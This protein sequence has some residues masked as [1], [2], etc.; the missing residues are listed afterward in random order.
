MNILVSWLPNLTTYWDKF[1]E[2]CLATF[3]MFFISGIFSFI[4]GLLF[5]VL[6]TV[7]K[8]G[9][10]AS[11]KIVYGIL[12][13]IINIF[14]AIPF[15]ILLIFLIPFTRAI[16]GTSIGVKGA[17]IPLV[18][19]CVPFFS[20]QVE[21]ALENV[22]PGKIEAARSMGSSTIGIIF[23]VYLHE[24]VPELI[25]VTTI[26]AI[27]LIGLTTMA[28]A[29]GAGGLGDFAI[30]Y[31][32]GLNHYDI[33][34]ACIIVLL[35]FTCIVQ[36]IGS[37]LAKKTTNREL[38]RFKTNDKKTNKVYTITSGVGFGLA[39]ILCI[40]VS[41]TISIGTQTNG[42]KE[43]KIGV[44][45]A[46]NDQW[47]AVQYV[48]DKQ[49]ANI[50]IDLVEFAAYDLPNQALDN[51]EIDLNSFQHN[52]YLEN[53][54]KNKLYNITAIGDTFLAPLTIYS[55]KYETLED[56]KTTA[57]LN[58]TNQVLNDALKI[59][60][61][62]DAT[63]QGRAIKLLE[64]AG[65]I[66]VNPDAKYTPETRDI[67]KY[68]YNIEVIAQAANTLPS[69]LDDYAAATIND[70]YANPAG[71]KREEDGIFIENKGDADNPYVNIIVSRENEKDNEVYK[72]IVEAFQTQIV[73]NFIYIEFDYS[74]IPAFD[75]TAFAELDENS[76]KEA[77]ELHYYIKNN[78]SL[79]ERTNTTTIILFDILIVL[80]AIVGVGVTLYIYEKK[81]ET[82]TKEI[83]E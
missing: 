78:V 5:G 14:R 68:I 19:G 73:A 36:F 38:F 46:T 52:A 69:T 32:Q 12:S 41:V 27:S 80:V 76:Q 13:V 66:E 61:P 8:K 47:K 43:V 81:H 48:L 56:L 37:Y 33:I 82:E 42:K 70:T 67:T 34:F 51:G 6:L 49:G 64:Q 59:A 31:G 29:V 40:I 17:I 30:N 58:G 55:K 25:R 2:N 20:R 18:F 65:L 72:Q 63:N 39:L 9:G 60:V 28:G 1:L 83:E 77:K 21:S 4:F 24:S 79:I 54:I 74:N 71:L 10:I 62:N 16:V 57:K 23:R 35:V 75:C 11:N 26:T 50:D 44:C 7:F 3:E 53:E 15:V 22:S 45:G